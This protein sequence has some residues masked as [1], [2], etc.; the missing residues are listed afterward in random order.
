MSSTVTIDKSVEKPKELPKVQ[1]FEDGDL[2]T[3]VLR[4]WHAFDPKT[5][6]PLIRD[7]QETYL[8]RITFTG[9]VGRNVAYEQAKQWVKIGLITKEHIFANDAQSDDFAKALG[10]DAMAPQTLAGAVSNL[11][12]EKAIA[13]LGEEAATSFAKRL[14]QDVSS[15]EKQREQ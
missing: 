14:L 4:G 5:R 13:I 3:V 10:R 2:V 6:Q 8:D 15:R 12:T 1:A 11:S 9:G 7:D